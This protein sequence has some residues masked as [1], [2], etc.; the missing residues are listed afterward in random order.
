MERIS[1]TDKIGR[2]FISSSICLEGQM[3][4]CFPSLTNQSLRHVVLR[5]PNEFLESNLLHERL[6]SKRSRVLG[7]RSLF[8]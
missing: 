3:I 1:R 5:H 4:G 6:L 7:E 8:S 2:S